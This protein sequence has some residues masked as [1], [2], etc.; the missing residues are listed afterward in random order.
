MTFEFIPGYFQ[1]LKNLY[2]I[3][4]P[5]GNEQQMVDFILNYLR[6][7]YEEDLAFF[8]ETSA[9]EVEVDE[10]N[11]ILITK[12][13]AETYPCLVAHLDQVQTYYPDD[14][15]VIVSAN[16]GRIYGY[17]E[18]EQRHIGLGADDKNGI[19]VALRM[20]REHNN[21]KVA[22]FTQEETDCLGSAAVDLSFF[23]DVQYIVQCDR[24]S[25]N[26]AA[27]E[28][29][30]EIHGMPIASEA[31][32]DKLDSVLSW[33]EF[34]D[35]GSTDVLMLTKRGV[36]K[37]CINVAS[38]YYNPHTDEE[39]TDLKDLENCLETVDTILSFV[40]EVYPHTL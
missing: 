36:G 26:E 6:Q 16:N 30:T 15:Q 10:M 37:S 27:D 8:G 11:N 12:G 28:I 25:N 2:A 5:S 1:L 14:L 35:G 9:V 20:L 31:F 22:F 33:S 29:V 23:D 13:K 3:H 39:Y 40:R 38:G 18:G 17:S 24:K 32:V 34:I 19:F 4:S 7:T 21:L